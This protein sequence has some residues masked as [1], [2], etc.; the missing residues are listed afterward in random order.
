MRN[1]ESS[2]APTFLCERYRCG[3]CQVLHLVALTERKDR[4]EAGLWINCDTGSGLTIKDSRKS[5]QK[6]GKNTACFE[7]NREKHGIARSK[8]ETFAAVFIIT[9]E[10]G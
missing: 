5:Q 8:H 2:L 1:C 3:V 10:P 6:S 4:R 9:D 7:K